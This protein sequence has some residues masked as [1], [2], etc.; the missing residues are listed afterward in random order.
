MIIREARFTS[1]CCFESN[2]VQR[3]NVPETVPPQVELIES[4]DTT[5]FG[6]NRAFETVS[7]EHETF[8]PRKTPQCRW[9][10]TMESVPPEVECFER[11]QIR[12]RAWD[13]TLVVRMARLT[14]EI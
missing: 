5:E 9:Y 3:K 4:G 7:S 6:G 8:Q 12:E 10:S 11:A 2:N 1:L 13:F 14:S